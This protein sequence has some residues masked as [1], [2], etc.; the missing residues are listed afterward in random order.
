LN[1]QRPVNPPRLPSEHISVGRPSTGPH[2]STGHSMRAGSAVVIGGNR[3][4][5]TSHF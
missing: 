5:D 2:L 3:Q 1:R 4:A